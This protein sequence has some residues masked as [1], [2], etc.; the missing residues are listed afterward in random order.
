MFG[1][2]AFWLRAAFYH[3][4]W[5]RSRSRVCQFSLQFLRTFS[6][7]SAY[8]LRFTWLRLRCPVG[9]MR[10]DLVCTLHVPHTVFSCTHGSYGSRVHFFL[11]LRT[12][13]HTY[14]LRCYG[15]FGSYV[16]IRLHLFRF[17]FRS[18]FLSSL[19]SISFVHSRLLPG[20]THTRFA[21]RGSDIFLRFSRWI[22]A[23]SLPTRFG[24][25]GLV[26][27]LSTWFAGSHTFGY[28]LFTLVAASPRLRTLYAV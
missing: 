24:S 1:Y 13:L 14:T 23:R 20:F 25:H 15:S 10:L 4:R 9:Y 7:R 2:T 21:L 8:W 18:L 26:F 27:A 19:P 11:W 16:Y 12:H 5:F 17:T 22:L 28:I 6:Y 3:A